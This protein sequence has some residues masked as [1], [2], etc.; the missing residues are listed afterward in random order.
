MTVI[1]LLNR[2]ELQCFHCCE[3]IVIMEALIF[4]KAGF[5]IS[6]I[7]GTYLMF[8]W[9]MIIETII[10]LFDRLCQ[11][12]IWVSLRQSPMIRVSGLQ[13]VKKK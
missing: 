9:F 10:Y 3:F 12:C 4:R 7:T 2:S 1:F 5:L 11:V 8:P 13:H 6:P